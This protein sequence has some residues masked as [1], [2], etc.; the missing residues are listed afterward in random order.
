M[1]PPGP[2]EYWQELE[3]EK[4][5]APEHQMW[6]YNVDPFAAK[7]E[8]DSRQQVAAKQKE[9]AQA[10]A[11]SGGTGSR[12]GSSSVALDELSHVPEVKMAHSLR[13]HVESV[14]KHVSTGFDTRGFTNSNNISPGLFRTP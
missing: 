8:V 3:A 14:I 2:K 10:G 12:S 6:M 9:K 5:A 1:L 11:E 4:K 7:K 13:E